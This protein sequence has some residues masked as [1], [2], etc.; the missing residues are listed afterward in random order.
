MSRYS[1]SGGKNY[2]C[3]KIGND[4]YGYKIS[5]MVDYYYAGSRLRYPRSFSRITDLKGAMRFCRKHRIDIKDTL[6]KQDPATPSS[7]PA[8]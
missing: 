1:S 7:N 3:R 8:N 2:V 6:S 5:W 4:Q